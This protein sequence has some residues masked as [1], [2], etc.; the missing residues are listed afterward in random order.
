MSQMVDLVVI[1]AGLAVAGW[2]VGWCVVGVAVAA[3]RLTSLVWPR[4]WKQRGINA[5]R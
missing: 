3:L 5:V 1:V 4:A 2:A